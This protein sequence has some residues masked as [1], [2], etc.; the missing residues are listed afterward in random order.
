M[1]NLNHV[2]IISAD[3]KNKINVDKV[4]CLSN[5]INHF[6]N[7]EESSVEE[8]LRKISD[9]FTL[10]ILSKDLIMCSHIVDLIKRSYLN[11]TPLIII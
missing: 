10:I 4:L 2:L 1:T 9:S 7:P 8:F 3:F 5:T 6:L 11:S